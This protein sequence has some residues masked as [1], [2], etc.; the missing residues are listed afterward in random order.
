[1]SGAGHPRKVTALST[2]LS[3]LHRAFSI[4]GEQY[5]LSDANRCRGSGHDTDIYPFGHEDAPLVFE[6]K[7]RKMTG[8]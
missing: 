7:A 3:S 5:S 2:S 1:M 4:H 6:V 8:K